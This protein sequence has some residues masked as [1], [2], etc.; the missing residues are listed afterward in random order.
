VRARTGYPRSPARRTCSDAI[1][2]EQW[3]G[4]LSFRLLCRRGG[5]SGGGLD[6][7][8]DGRRRA[9]TALNANRQQRG[10]DR[11]HVTFF[12]KQ[13]RHLPGVRRRKLDGSLG[14]LDLYERLVDRYLVALSHQ[15]AQYLSLSQA[16]P[17]VRKSELQVL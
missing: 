13:L 10:A 17:D 12:G 3:P 1:T 5:N 2:D 15:P 8:H 9:R 4:A 6:L 7:W 16:L 11:E 14:S